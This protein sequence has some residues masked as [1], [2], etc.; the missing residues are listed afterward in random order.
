MSSEE[1][2]NARQAKRNRDRLDRLSDDHDYDYA[3]ENVKRVRRA[4]KAARKLKKAA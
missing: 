4:L 2:R 3:K 1:D